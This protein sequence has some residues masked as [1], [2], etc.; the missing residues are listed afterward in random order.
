MIRPYR[1]APFLLLLLAACSSEP[2]EPYS[3]ADLA[4]ARA[5]FAAGDYP[6]AEDSMSE[7]RREYFDRPSQ[8]EYSLLAGDIAYELEDYDRAIHNYEEYLLFSGVARESERIEKRLFEMALDLLEARRLVL[9][10][11]TDRGRGVVTLHNLA[12]WAP[13]SPYAPR[14]LA[15]TANY[16]YDRGEFGEAAIDYRLLL[17]SHPGSEFSDLANFR[18]GMCGRLQIDGPWVDA[19]MIDHSAA[20][21]RYYL[22][23]Y[24]S[25]LYRAEAEVSL[26]ELERLGAEREL[27]LGDYYLTIGNVR[28]ARLHYQQARGRG[29]REVADVAEAR[30]VELPPNPPLAVPQEDEAG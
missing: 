3:T 17:E 27:L 6:A 21:L 22:D 25:G 29:V 8:G 11:F 4:E 7:L 5:L 15:T 24:P 16:S 28:G 30:L 12:A 13:S 23:H 1:L 2:A 18:L 14:A 10:I 19:R 26:A 9:G 20:Q